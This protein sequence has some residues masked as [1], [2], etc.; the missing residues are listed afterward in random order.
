MPTKERYALMSSEQ[1][2][3]HRKTAY[4]KERATKEGHI[5]Q[6]FSSRK[7]K[8]KKEKITFNVSL[9]YI[10]SIAPLICPV[11]GIEL[12]WTKSTGF[13]TCKDSF[14]SMDR[15]NPS[16]GYIEGNIM[17]MSY[18][19]NRMK[20]N[21]TPEQLCKFADWIKLNIKE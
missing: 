9:D 20:S 8:A 10:I 4:Y 2:K 14:P 19:A 17:W 21:A 13:D 1:K 12:S 15:I 11:L 5:R 7:C 16:L 6:I 3:K 18:L